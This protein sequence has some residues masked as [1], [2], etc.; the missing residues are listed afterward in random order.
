MDL[1]R[2]QR[3][4]VVFKKRKCREKTQ[5]NADVTGVPPV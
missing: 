3:P 2:T 1:D 4:K 5:N